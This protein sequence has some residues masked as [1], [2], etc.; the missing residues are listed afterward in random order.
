MGTAFCVTVDG[1]FLT[2]DHVV[3]PEV[4]RG[5]NDEIHLAQIGSDGHTATLL[6]P[7][8]IIDSSSSLDFA[9]LQATLGTQRI[10]KYLEID[11]SARFEGEE[12]AICGYPLASVSPASPNDRSLF[13]DA[14][15]RVAAGI[16]SSQNNSN[17]KL[18]LE[19]DFPILRGN[20]GG[21]LFSQ[22]SGKVLG[23]SIA[24]VAMSNEHNVTIGHLGIVRDIRALQSS[25]R[26]LGRV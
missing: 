20:S 4:P 10:Q 23:I 16:I 14:K 18:T 8:S 21:P 26:K 7:C 12:V 15:L 13:L 11:Y 22:D 5:P 17:G 24:T 25:L 6:G 19:V 9:I 3:N 2:A 1:H